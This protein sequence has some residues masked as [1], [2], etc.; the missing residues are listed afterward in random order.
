MTYEEEQAKERKTILKFVLWVVGIIL[1]IAFLSSCLTKIGAGQRGV[2]LEWGAVSDT[3]L[4]EG[5]HFKV[6]IYQK[7]VKLDVTTQKEETKNIDSASKDLQTVTTDVAINYHLDTL[8]VNRVYQTLKTKYSVR[9]IEPSIEEFVKKT[10]AEFT[11]EELITKRAEVKATLKDS[12]TT[13]LAT[14]NIIVE[15][16]FITNFTFSEQFDKAIESKVTAEQDALAAKNKLEQVKFEAEQRI[17]Q[18]KAEAEAIKIQA[19]AITQ[20]GGRDY[21]NLK[22]VEK[23]DGKLPT[24]MI[25]N[26]TM[27][28]INLTN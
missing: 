17:A 16:M 24:Q 15:D 11:A 19:E 10:M 2:V 26:A 7:I 21:V 28:F 8:K 12:I 1:I 23:W 18:A 3:I 6:P 22:A 5:L 9:V 13:S 20:Q 27:P 14:H 4:D 25:P